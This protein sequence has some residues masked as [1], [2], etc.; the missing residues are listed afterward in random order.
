MT[1]D[2]LQASA[3]FRLEQCG[4]LIC[5]WAT[6]CGKSGVVLKFLKA[7]PTYSC[8][9]L[10]PEQ[11]NI[12]NWSYEFDKFGVSKDNVVIMCYASFHKMEQTHWDL[13]VF[14]EMPHIDTEKRLAICQS[15][16]G[17][18]ILA[19]AAVIDNDER[20]SLE[21]TYGHFVSSI[22][23]LGMAMNWGILPSPT[24]YIVHMELDNTV[25]KHFVKGISCTDKEYYEHVQAKVERA[26]NAYED[27]PNK[28]TRNRMLQAGSE[29]KRLL[30]KLKDDAIGMICRELESKRKRF[31]CFCSSIKQAE[32]LGGSNAFTSKTPASL[33]LLD[34]FNNG[35]INSLFVVGKLIE[36][37][38]LRNIEC[39]V[40]GQLGGTQRITVQSIGRIMRSDNPIIYVPTFDG[41]KDE[42]FLYTLT[43]SIPERCIKHY[44]FKS[45]S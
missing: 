8:L 7:H 42:S 13:L 17:D 34:R 9:I 26:A 4:K 30:G 28:F 29:R 25:K 33:K 38:N 14:D 12:E 23:T 44:K 16:T 19:L 31:L 39:G 5:Q 40:I 21:S 22:V 1:K 11:N 27:N 24:V 37:Q 20:H 6:G 43:S 3:V 15:V 10:V 41:T 18:Y 35:E 32:L 36:G 45:I 2:E